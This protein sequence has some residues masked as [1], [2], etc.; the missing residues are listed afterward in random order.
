MKQILP[1]LCLC[2]VLTHCKKEEV[3]SDDSASISSIQEIKASSFLTEGKTKFFPQNSIDN[4][5]QPWCVANTDKEPTLEITF[6][7]IVRTK[8]LHFLNGYA[9]GSLFKKNSRISKLTLTVD[10]GIPIELEI[11]DA[12]E[13]SKS[14]T[15]ELVGKKFTLSIKDKYPGD[16]YQ[17]LCLTELSFDDFD[18]DDHLYFDAFCSEIFKDFKKIEFINDNH[19]ITLTNDNRLTAFRSPAQMDIKNE[20]TGKWKFINE[21][22]SRILEGKYKITLVQNANDDLTSDEARI[23]T[24]HFDGEFSIPLITDKNCKKLNGSRKIS[25]F[26]EGDPNKQYFPSD[27]EIH[28]MK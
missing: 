4:S 7:K 15:Q 23:V 16:N 21:N 8:Y 13:Y 6:N 9:K 20:G 26:S 2:V 11:P 22:P 3:K 25:V 14:F 27:D 28:I 18:F 17:D 10:N 12:I 19:Y 5:I 1:I 24:T